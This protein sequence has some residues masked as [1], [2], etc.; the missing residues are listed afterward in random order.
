MAKSEEQFAKAREEKETVEQ[1]L[2]NTQIE[3]SKL[4][5][6][7]ARRKNVM[8]NFMAKSEE[9]FAK[10]RGE[11]ELIEAELNNAR[12]E[13]ENLEARLA[14]RK[15]VMDNFMSK[16]EEQFAKAREENET[17]K[18]ELEHAAQFVEGQNVSL[19]ELD[20]AKTQIEQLQ[21]QLQRM[22]PEEEHAAVEQQLTSTAAE[23]EEQHQLYETCQEQLSSAQKDLA[24]FRQELELKGQELDNAAVA[25]T[26]LQK[27][28]SE[29]QHSDSPA[30]R[31]ENETLKGTVAHLQKSLEEARSQVRSPRSPRRPR[32]GTVESDVLDRLR[33]DLE[34]RA[35]TVDNALR[36][37]EV[38][39]K[40]CEMIQQR[41][42]TEME[43]QRGLAGHMRET[44]EHFDKTS[45]ERE[46]IEEEPYWSTNHVA[47]SP[48]PTFGWPRPED[49]PVLEDYV[50]ALTGQRNSVKSA[51]QL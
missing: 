25:F 11:K 1:D 23:F 36:L 30:L 41:L 6:Q 21:G 48:N 28:L 38:A 27:D 24:A 22:V 34:R 32:S 15:N 20:S 19:N 50:D 31:D 2:E 46:P 49:F 39:E 51:K 9:Q 5:D 14:R 37:Q 29:A 17:L 3:I 13:I 40:R 47:G 12:V 43:R 44:L 26:Q 33:K 8:D 18:Q 35:R 45:A 42:N 16:S 4:T 7:L 10:T